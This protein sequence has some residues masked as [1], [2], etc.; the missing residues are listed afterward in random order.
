M[1][2]VSILVPSYNHA[3][4]LRECLDSAVAQTFEDWELIL[5][6]DASSDDSASIAR[7][8]EDPRVRVLVN[9]E[10][11][12]T[13]GALQRGLDEASGEF[14]AV[15]N[16]DDVWLPEKIH[17]QV[18]LMR[19][20][21]TTQFCYTLGDQISAEGL[22]HANQHHDWPRDEVQELL[23]FLLRENRILASSVMFRREG[24]RFHTECRY[25]GDWIALLEHAALGPCVCVPEPMTLWRIHESNSHRRSPGQLEEEI[26]L[27]EGIRSRRWH[28]TGVLQKAV[29]AG[30]AQNEMHLAALYVLAG[31]IHQARMA[32]IRGLGIRPSSAAAKRVAATHL[33]ARA[34]KRKL[35]PSEDLSPTSSDRSP[36]VWNDPDPSGPDADESKSR[37]AS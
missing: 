18:V 26:W 3:Q 29:K 12:G 25:S 8:F 13:Y 37:A 5:V 21:P 14:V 17:S 9:G 2:T 4:Y 19:D 7:S 28:R 32:A 27:R 33:P 24:L 30:L 36:L 31:S 35:W 16:S 34:A 15:L 22:M 10:N 20:H 23:P 1:P 6:D 11:L